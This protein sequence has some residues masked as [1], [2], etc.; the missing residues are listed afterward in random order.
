LIQVDVQ[1]FAIAEHAAAQAA[2]VVACDGSLGGRSNPVPAGGLGR[3]AHG[4]ALA[5]REGRAELAREVR[6]DIRATVAD[7]PRPDAGEGGADTVKAMPPHRLGRDTEDRGR[8]PLV[9]QGFVR[10]GEY[11]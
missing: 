11:S 3:G 10:H 6:F 2:S 4:C 7:Q 1:L 9:K 5:L 8:L